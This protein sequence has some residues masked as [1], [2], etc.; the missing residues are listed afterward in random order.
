MR[1][2]GEDGRPHTRREA[3]GGP[4]PAHA[5]TSGPQPPGPGEDKCV[6]PPGCDTL[7]SCSLTLQTAARANTHTVSTASC[8][9]FD[10]TRG[11]GCAQVH[12]TWPGWDSGLGRLTPQDSLL[13]PR[14]LPPSACSFFSE[15]QTGCRKQDSCLPKEAGIR[16]AFELVFSRT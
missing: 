1:T 14:A 8:Q 5:R 3:S 4:G 7:S 11:T 6:S 12:G 15:L 13:T 2:Q 10:D 9:V 16:T